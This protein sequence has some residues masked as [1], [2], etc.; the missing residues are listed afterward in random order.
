MWCLGY[1]GIG[2]DDSGRIIRRQI[3]EGVVEAVSFDSYQ[4]SCLSSEVM[5]WA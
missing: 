5:L 4:R 3:D 1:Q 2:Y